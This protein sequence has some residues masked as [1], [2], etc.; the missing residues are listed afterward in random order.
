[1]QRVSELLD[2]AKALTTGF[3]PGHS[4]F[5]IEHFIIGKQ[6]TLYAQYQQCRREIHNRVEELER[7]VK[8][9]WWRRRKHDVHREN[10]IRELAE[11][12]ELAI[13]LK[14][15]LG[16]MMPHEEAALEL[17]SWVWRVRRQLAIDLLIDKRPS[18]STMDF[19][20]SLPEGPRHTILNLLGGTGPE[21]D[22]DRMNLMAWVYRGAP[23]LE[24]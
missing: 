17:E 9:K 1:M 5:Q 24:A 16:P 18:A 22:A 3:H 7:K 11:F 15:E 21:A 12:V 23:A 20:L 8:R 19:I 4:R 6:G 14:A 13:V 10:A 2:K